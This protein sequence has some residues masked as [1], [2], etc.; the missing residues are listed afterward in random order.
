MITITELY[1]QDYCAWALKN[2]ELLRQGRLA[3]IDLEHVV[4]ELEELMGNT[5][6]ELYRRLRILLA[7]LLKWQ[8]QPTE[9]SGGWAG[10]VRTQRQDIAKLF[11]DNPSLKRYLPEELRDAY[12]DAVELAAAE[13][14]KPIAAFPA[15]CPYTT[16]QVLSRDF[17][18]D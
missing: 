10:T 8:H 16:E 7:H 5:R 2:A 18:P 17:W 1:D 15:A 3:E 11:K 9:R 4:E 14:G 6:R 13:T 12:G